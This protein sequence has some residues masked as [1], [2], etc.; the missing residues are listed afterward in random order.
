MA[1]S[2][3]GGFLQKAS[4]AISDGISLSLVSASR[5]S[6]M[7]FGTSTV[8]TVK[9]LVSLDGINFVPIEGI[10]IG[11]SSAA[12]NTTSTNS[13]GWNFP[14]VAAWSHLRTQISAIENGNVSILANAIA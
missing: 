1:S 8:F 14:D 4:T 12:A 13:E 5:A 6:I 10:K 2:V 7:I 11:D 9:F 3:N